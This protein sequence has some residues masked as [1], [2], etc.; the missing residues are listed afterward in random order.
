MAT[1]GKVLIFL[2]LLLAAGVAYLATQSWA[3]RQEQ[4]A[5]AFRYYLI[6]RG[7]P[8]EGEGISEGADE[9]AEVPFEFTMPTGNKITSVRMGFLKTHFAG[10]ETGTYSSPT[11]PA[12]RLSEVKRVRAKMQATLSGQRPADKLRSLVGSMNEAT[13]VFTA[14]L[15]VYLADSF[16]ERQALKQLLVIQKPGDLEANAK[17]AEDLILKRFDAVLAPPIPNSGPKE[18]EIIE[19]GTNA[20]KAAADDLAKV[21]TDR[22]TALAAMRTALAAKPPVAADVEM[23]TNQYK[24]VVSK[25]DN[26][27][28]RLT[29]AQRDLDRNLRELGSTTATDDRDRIMRM[30]TLLMH[31]DFDAPSESWQ[32]RVAL[33]VGLPDYLAAIKNRT[34]R[35]TDYPRRI[36]ETRNQVQARFTEMYLHLRTIAADRDVLLLRQQEITTALADQA[37]EETNLTA[38][39]KTQRDQAEKDKTAAVEAVNQAVAA[40]TAIE[41][42][43]FSIQ[44]Q[45]GRILRD[46]FALED[47]IEAA[48]R[49]KS[50]GR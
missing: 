36:T 24:I 7:L 46:N 11:P 23:A 48:E 15:L 31:L 17:Q 12:S 20:I 44:K 37:K 16:D 5:L 26:A 22:N 41:D 14:G 50:G 25:Y 34:E 45:V 2:N 1:I 32:K 39:R 13:Q 27:N 29:Q 21:H 38:Q 18:K 9:E 19:S 4:N 3:Q 43:L 42:E 8:L 10:A 33:V 47:R 28:L 30:T 6:T 40:Q 35:L 49:Q